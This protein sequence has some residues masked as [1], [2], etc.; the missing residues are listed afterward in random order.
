MRHVSFASRC[1]VSL[2]LALTL[3]TSVAR[4]QA[5]QPGAA[6][7]DT[8]GRA[9]RDT[10]RAAVRDSLRPSAHDFLAMVEALP[11]VTHHSIR[12]HG[13]T[14]SYTATTGMLPI[15]N[16]TTGAIEGGMFFVAY[17]KDGV[18]DTNARPIS[19]IFNGGPGSAT[20][21]LHMGAFGPKKV[22]LNPDGT[23]SPPPYA[24]EDNQSTLLDQSDLVFLDPVGTGFSRAARPELGPKFWGLDED[25]R[26][27][28]E[29]VRLYLTRYDRW[30]SPKFVAGE[31]Y[32]TTR[33]A[34]LSGYLADRGIALNGVVLISTVLNF[35]ASAMD[36][37][38]DLGFVN[39]L[40]S[41][42]ATAWY[43]K[44]LPADLQKLTVQQ[45]ATQAEKWAETDYASA[46][47][48]GARLTDAQRHATAEQ[49]A[50]F[51]GT[52][53]IFAE[54]NDLRITLARFNQELLRD[55]HLT[56]GRLDSRFTTYA[57]DQ[58]AERGQFDPS[59]ASIRNSFSPVMSEYARRELGYR[60]EDVYYILGGGIGRWRY[61][62]NNGYAN[63]VPSLERA[64]AKNP[65]MKLYVA[66]GYYD[67][68]T[69][70]YAV[71]YTLAHMSVDPR[72]R[73][74]IVTERF[75]AGHM[76]YIDAPSM[77]KMREGLRRFIDS[78]LPQ[79]QRA[80]R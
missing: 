54:E 20:V 42:A 26:A 14:L 1:C 72:V 30:G 73:A 16:D 53:T 10:L 75:E 35:G 46:L 78:A 56:S 48:R 9:G 19:F 60:N 8:T 61:P 70:Y 36:A 74:G 44:K 76:V 40:P 71:E 27:V 13:A 11:V 34:H 55:Q 39:F 28:G 12:L 68:A 25:I 3:G 50:R 47:M 63:V 23:N 41:Y 80:E 4:A 49:L 5:R 6:Q 33:A 51:T 52:S 59:E 29:F 24:Y 65:D 64:F 62:Q 67:M 43:H 7:R 57:T 31:S 58:G 38:N 2:L 18:G 45:V 66:E 32:G 15:R 69:P 79:A 21:W 17:N 37:G 77:T 22:H